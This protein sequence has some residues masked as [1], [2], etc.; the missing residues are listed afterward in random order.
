VDY[1]RRFPWYQVLVT[2]VQ[3][4]L[5]TLTVYVS[6]RVG[7]LIG[8]A[9]GLEEPWQLYALPVV[10]STGLLLLIFWRMGLYRIQKSIMNVE[11]FQ[12]ILK[13]A[14]LGF[15]IMLSLVF[16]LDE[17]RNTQPN[18]LIQV[19][20][21]LHQA[22]FGG[23][24]MVFS[25]QVVIYSFLML[26]GF[27]WV[28][29]YFVFKAH[30][31][32][33]A[34]GFGNKRILI[35]GAGDLG[36]ILTKRIMLSP[37]LG[38]YVVAF[39]DKDP[40]KTGARVEGKKV[41]VSLDRL[42]RLI[43]MLRIDL[44]LVATKDGFSD[45]DV[46]TIMTMCRHSRCSFQIVPRLFGIF[47]HHVSVEYLDGIP[48]VS[49]RE[50]RMTMVARCFKRTMDLVLAGLA[51]LLAWPVM[52]MIAVLVRRQSRGSALFRQKRVGKDGRV[53]RIFKFRTMYVDTP[54][55]AECPASCDESRITPIGRW[56]RKY[57]LD[58]LPQMFNVLA[59]NMSIVGPR[60]EMPFIVEQ[61]S[62]Y[63]RERLRVKPG[64]TGLWQV[65]RGRGGKKIH[66]NIGYDIYYVEHQ[67]PLL[68]LVILAKTV[69]V[70]LTGRGV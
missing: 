58:E 68:D 44:V 51:V 24:P 34:R 16:F 62:R 3:V 60:P 31:L 69:P 46:T 47:L 45:E 41:F 52:L 12:G 67:S 56:L 53:F 57:S 39:V 35:C 55:Y 42:P 28:Q 17:V 10:F 49:L 11:E 36:R 4:V 19:Y 14:V 29:R 5:D 22:V 40:S 6:F 27:L 61:Y 70:V 32:L 2:F 66:S 38:Y 18:G 26:L 33:H 64:I 7:N 50:P 65:S 15:L 37:K 9:R 21:E 48:L 23:N 43:R 30:Q 13:A 54:R 8:N 20:R 63:E 59:G 1:G 25:R